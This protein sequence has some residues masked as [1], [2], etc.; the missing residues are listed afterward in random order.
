V[1]LV[2]RSVGDAH[3]VTLNV[4]ALSDVSAPHVIE[5]LVIHDDDPHA[6][7][8]LDNPD[9]VVPRPLQTTVNQTGNITLTVPPV[10]WVAVAFTG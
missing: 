8:T 7:N 1:F 2:N 10:S 4:A 6:G 3:T 9:R 5:T